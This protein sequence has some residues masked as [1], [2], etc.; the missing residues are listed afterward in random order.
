VQAAYYSQ[1][2]VVFSSL[3]KCKLLHR[4]SL[5]SNPAPSTLANACRRNSTRS[6]HL[7]ERTP[8]PPLATGLPDEMCCRNHVLIITHSVHHVFSQMS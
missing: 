2:R 3:E 6:P 5:Q 4:N 1:V 7:L 8:D